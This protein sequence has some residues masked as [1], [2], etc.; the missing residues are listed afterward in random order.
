MLDLLRDVFLFA[1][2]QRKYWLIPLILV[3]LL[4]GL[5]LVLSS[6]SAVAPLLYT[7]F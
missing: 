6:T 1:R 5:V 4:L 2:E 3:L 7:L